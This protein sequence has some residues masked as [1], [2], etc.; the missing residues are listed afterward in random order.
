MN[1]VS[2]IIEVPETGRDDALHLV[3]W[4]SAARRHLS[5]S[6]TLMTVH[7]PGRKEEPVLRLRIVS[8]RI[9]EG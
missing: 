7:D 6:G 2:L 8:A 1:T 5:S 9:H 3:E 4:M